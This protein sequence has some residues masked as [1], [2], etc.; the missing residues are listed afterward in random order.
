MSINSPRGSSAWACGFIMLSWF[1]HSEH[2]SKIPRL[3]KRKPTQNN[4]KLLEIWSCCLQK[5]TEIVPTSSNVLLKEYIFLLSLTF[6]ISNT[7]EHRLSYLQW[8][9]FCCA[10]LF[11]FQTKWTE[12]VYS[13]SDVRTISPLGNQLLFWRGYLSE[14]IKKKKEKKGKPHNKIPNGQKNR[15]PWFMTTYELL[16]SLTYLRFQFV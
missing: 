1:R 9:N 14:E 5:A 10:T 15:N 16:I 11:S 6:M 13:S 7:Q 3:K 12:S 8:N 4:Y 2:W